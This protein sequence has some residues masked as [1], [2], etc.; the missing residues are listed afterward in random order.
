[1]YFNTMQG[2][3]LIELMVVIAIMGI[4]A[5]IALPSLTEATL[6]SQLRANAN[7]LVSSVHFARGEA[8]KR[9]KVTTLC[10]SSN[11][12]SCTGAWKDGWVVLD[13]ATV[14]SVENA[15][16]TG[17]IITGAVSTLS[18]QPTGVGSTQSTLTV[19]RA[20]PSVGS[21]ERQVT[22]SATGRVSVKKTTAGS[23]A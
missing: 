12:T 2:F 20:T 7:K 16:S 6:S 23:C 10:A 17:F 22:I 1:M 15:L 4:L 11:G 9:N 18:F 19:C 8:I 5:A 3:N 21:Q 14:L 13:G